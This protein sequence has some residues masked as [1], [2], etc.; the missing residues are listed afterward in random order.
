MF[1][2]TPACAGKTEEYFVAGKYV[3][4]HPRVCGKNV[5]LSAFFPALLGS[6]PRVREKL[7]NVEQNYPERGITPACAGKTKLCSNVPEVSWDHPRVCGKNLGCCCHTI[8]Y[9]GSPPRVREKLRNGRQLEWL[10]RITPACAGKTRHRLR[11][12][13]HQEDHPRVCG[14][15]KD[16]LRDPDMREGS[17]P[18]VREK[19]LPTCEPCGNVRITPA[20]AGKTI[21]VDWFE[22][23]P[24][25]HPRVCGKNF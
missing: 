16:I 14:K 24:E 4:D 8:Q 22:N 9:R 13:R 20:C 5:L 6:P 7:A 12:L 25:D 10:N 11:F 2:I 1:G 19:P 15:N 18:R 3:R 21:A 23:P 17:P